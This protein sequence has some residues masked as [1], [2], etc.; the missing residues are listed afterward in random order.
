VCRPLVVGAFWTPVVE[1]A[2]WVNWVIVLLI[3]SGIGLMLGAFSGW[4][5]GSIRQPVTAPLVG[6]LLGSV[7]AF[8]SALVT[9]L[10]LCV[11]TAPG[12]KH[13]PRYQRADVNLNLYWP[14]M[15][16]A[17]ALPGIGG[18]LA[19]YRARQQRLREGAS[20]R[21]E[22]DRPADDTSERAN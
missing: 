8:G 20:R 21:E 18:G 4:V 14:M 7:L 6:A 9:F 10:F 15:G 19:G 3:S 22:E 17:G 13:D 12:P 5:A 16:L 11:A 1:T 2:A